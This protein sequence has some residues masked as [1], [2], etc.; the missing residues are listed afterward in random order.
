[1]STR[2]DASSKPTSQLG[3]LGALFANNTRAMFAISCRTERY[4]LWPIS[5]SRRTEDTDGS[6][7]VRL[8]SVRWGT[9]DCRD[10]YQLIESRSIEGLVDGRSTIGFPK[11][12]DYHVTPFAVQS[13]FYQ[14]RVGRYLCDLPIIL[15]LSECDK[16]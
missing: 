10:S 15:S 5:P 3:G 6:D 16:Y 4:Q 14:W 13:S 7:Q 8:G 1:M 9:L 11:S 2:D 12:K